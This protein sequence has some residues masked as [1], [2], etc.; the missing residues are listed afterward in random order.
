[1]KFLIQKC[2]KEVRH[3]F[4]FA[5]L[6]AIRFNNWFMNRKKVIYKFIDTEFD[7][8]RFTKLNFKPEHKNYVPIG[9]VDFVTAHLQYFH[10]ITPKPQNIP[11]D[12]LKPEFLQRF[13]F[14]GTERE[15]EGVKFVKSN[16]KIK[17]YTEIVNDSTDVPEGNYQISDVITID[18]EWRAF[19]YQ[20]KLVGLQNYCGEFTLFP[21]VSTIKKMIAEYKSAPIAYTLDVGVINTPVRLGNYYRS[22]FIDTFII[23]VHDFFSCGLYGFAD[24]AILPQMFQKWFYEYLNKNKTL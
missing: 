18:S 10:N 6:E 1:M 17:A 4:A 21:Q 23:E 15:I 11:I 9:S 2:Y 24:L 13:V 22:H 20:G 12:L 14:N 7:D 5:L 16:D 3:D 19:I 8:N